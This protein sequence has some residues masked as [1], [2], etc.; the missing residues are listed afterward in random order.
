MALFEHSVFT[1]NSNTVRT[2]ALFAETSKTPDF[3]PVMCLSDVP[4]EGYLHLKPIF[5]QFCVE[6]PTE[7][8]F[9]IHVFGSWHIWERVCEANSVKYYVDR[10]RAE[11]D[12]ARK[13]T[14]FKAIIKEARQGKTPTAAA[15]YLI[16]EPWKGRTKAAKEKTK[17]TATQAYSSVTSDIER[18]KEEGLLN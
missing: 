7:Y 11:C 14:A 4:K 5:L 6:D 13:R 3:T 15:R 10:W 18:L 17:E 9:A 12:I 8:D 2:I 16:E 1:N